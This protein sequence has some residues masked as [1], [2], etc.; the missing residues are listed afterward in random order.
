MPIFKK[1]KKDVLNKRIF[2]HLKDSSGASEE[3]LKINKIR[4]ESILERLKAMNMVLSIASLVIPLA[5]VAISQSLIPKDQQKVFFIICTLFIFSLFFIVLYGV[6]RIQKAHLI[7]KT[8]DF[9]IEQLE[10]DKEESNKKNKIIKL[11]VERR[12]RI[13]NQK[14]RK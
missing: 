6:F 7:I 1:R 8:L 10:K 4:I 3:V 12:E 13:L 14:Y 9:Q 2:Q 5:V 11:N